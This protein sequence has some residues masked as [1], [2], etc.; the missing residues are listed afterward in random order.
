MNDTNE[1]QK[2]LDEIQAI[3]TKIVVLDAQ[4]AELG[5]KKAELEKK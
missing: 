2:A 3:D 1:K 4:I 5:V